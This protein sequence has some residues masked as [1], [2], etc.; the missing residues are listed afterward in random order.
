MLAA[1]ARTNLGRGAAARLAPASGAAQA[2]CCRPGAAGGCG[3]AP[4][5]VFAQCA[6]GDTADALAVATGDRASA[7]AAAGWPPDLKGQMR[8]QQHLARTPAG[9]AARI[10]QRILALTI[11][12]LVNTLSGR[13]ARALAAYDG[14]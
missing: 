12:M 7:V 11:G 5:A 10:A 1:W 2:R 13:P 8:L 3:C 6:V 14:R 4:D 9:L